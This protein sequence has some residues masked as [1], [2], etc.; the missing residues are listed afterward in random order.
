MERTVVLC[1]AQFEFGWYTKPVNPD[2]ELASMTPTGPTGSQ[3]LFNQ[4]QNLLQSGF[5]K[6]ASACK[7]NSPTTTVVVICGEVSIGKGRCGA[8]V[9]AQLVGRSLPLP[10]V[11]S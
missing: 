4:F 7:T 1:D 3:N 8:V 9:L 11:R 5:K 10:E 2:P 6:Q